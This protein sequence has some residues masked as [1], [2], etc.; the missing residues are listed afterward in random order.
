MG[1]R[2]ELDTHGHPRDSYVRTCPDCGRRSYASRPL[3][4][5]AARAM[6]PGQSLR[7]Y[8]CGHYWHFGPIQRK[9]EAQ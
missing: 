3:A 4:K 7:P 8:R 1:R 6:F 2:P 5:R 9:A